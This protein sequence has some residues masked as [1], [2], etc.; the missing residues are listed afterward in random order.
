MNLIGIRIV[1]KSKH[2][3]SPSMGEGVITD[4]DGQFITMVFDNG[5]SKKLGL[6]EVFKAEII[7]A[8]DP[9]IQQK[10]V[11]FI[12]TPT[13]PSPPL[14]VTRQKVFWV[15]QNQTYDEESYNGYIYAPLHGPHHWERLKE[16]RA[17]DIIIHS[18]RAEVV[19]ISVARDVAY[20]WI[21]YDGIQGRRIDCD[22]YRLRRCLSTSLRKTKNIELC[23]GAMYQPFNSNGTGNQGYLYDMT[24]KLRDYYVSEIVK[25]NPEILD[26]IPELKKFL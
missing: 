21:R 15:F 13:P 22:Y 14:P 18:Y 16:V 8:V 23:A 24:F 26:K 10:I 7:R 6:R 12:N 2:F 19:A 25:Y 5:E 20:L 1:H 3:S 4:F 11:G 17:G 9:E